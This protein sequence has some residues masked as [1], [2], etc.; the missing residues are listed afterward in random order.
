MKVYAFYLPQYHRV[1]SNDIWWG[2][3]FTEWTSAKKAK[4][5]YSNHYQ[6]H[7]P[8]DDN[9][10]NLLD[11]ETMVWQSQLM[12]QY[13]V[14]GMCFYHYWFS[15]DEMVLEK[16]AENLLAW[17][18]VNMPF[19]F[20]WANE[21][22]LNKWSNH[23]GIQWSIDSIQKKTKSQII[24]LQQYKREEWKEHFDYL[25]QF[26]LDDRYIKIEGKPLFIIYRLNN[27]PCL[28]EMLRFWNECAIESGFS[29]IYVIGQGSMFRK[30]G[31]DVLMTHE[32]SSVVRWIKPIK[33]TQSPKRYSYDEAW[34]KILDGRY[35]EEKKMV[36]TALTSYD[37]T[38]RYGDTGVVYEGAVPEKFENYLTQLLAKNEA[39]GVDMTLINAWNE[40]G[41]GM[42]LEP[43]KRDRYGWLE[44]LR[45][46]K[47]NYKKYVD[48]YKRKNI[49][50]EGDEY[51]LGVHETKMQTYF[52]TFNKWM[53][54]RE[55]GKNATEYLKSKNI[56]NILIYGSGFLA[57][58]FLWECRKDRINV[59]GIIDE[60]A[61]YSM[62][63]IPVYRIQDNLPEADAIVVAAFFHMHDIVVLIRQYNKDINIYS[64]DELV[65]LAEC[66]VI[67]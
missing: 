5:L 47:D 61:N 44:A 55:Y 62:D 52:D 19:F 8:L 28:E 60:S 31:V 33:G 11:K 6:P 65:S 59:C 48:D 3:G 50:I 23:E 57:D 4:P 14:D 58:H 42:H 29:G 38:P 25:L 39:S 2:E 9:Y 15:K 26:F 16:P 1:L 40:W 41:E 24:Y 63:N 64:L 32:P 54:I 12:H 13:G 35:V 45:N 34:E 49:K 17:K 36:Y 67:V 27:I 51:I 30:Y 66:V 10:Y 43:D 20:A 18:E 46:A 7:E 56:N 53:S 37:T 22:W 21:S